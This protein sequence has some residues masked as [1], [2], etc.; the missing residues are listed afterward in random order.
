MRFSLLLLLILSEIFAQEQRIIPLAPSINEIVYA[1]GKGDEVVANTTYATYPKEAQSK[2]K[3]GGYFSVSLEK[4]LALKPSLVLMQRNNLPLIPKLKKFGIKAKLIRISSLNDIKE[5]IKTIGRLTETQDRAEIIVKNIENAIKDTQGILKDKKI[6]IVFGRQFDLKKSIYVS[7][8]SIYFADII[9]ASG[10]QNA[11]AEETTKQ[12]L[13]SYEGII[14][15]NP[16]IIYILAHLLKG[17]KEINDL[18]KTWQT[19]PVTAAKAKTIYVTTKEYSGRPSQ[20]VVNY[21]EDF[22]DILKDAKEKL[23]YHDRE[24]ESYHDR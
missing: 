18:V 3:V 11:F 9:R 1:L 22:R 10:N 24:K 23:Y 16:D 20:R 21:I 12:P 7:G 2:P 17:E 15:T 5:G 19:L 8:N 6:L 13:L 4:I 14:A